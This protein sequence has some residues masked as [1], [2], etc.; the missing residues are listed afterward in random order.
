MTAVPS[1]EAVLQRLRAEANPANVAGMA[2]YGIVVDGALGITMPVLRGIAKELRP[3]RKSDPAALHDLAAGLWASGVHEARI[4]AALVDVPSLVTRAQA[5]TW[6]ADLDS[7]DVC[8]GLCGNLLDKTDFAFE[9]AEDWAGDPREFVKRAGFS[10]MAGL[11]VHDKA[12][13]DEPFLYFLTLVEREAGDERNFVKKAV[14]WALRQIGKRNRHL[15]EVAVAVASRMRESDS[16]AARWVASDAL[17]E[18]TSE[19]VL[20]RLRP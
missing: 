16:R 13:A 12:A 2:R 8:D 18:L 10:L 1:A 19:Q 20:A 4:L 17:R 9:A 14:N 15:N 11:T 6:V 3:A 7:W 5:D